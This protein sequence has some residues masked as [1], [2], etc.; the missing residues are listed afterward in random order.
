VSQE[1]QCATLSAGFASI[2]PPSSTAKG[3]SAQPYDACITFAT[4]LRRGT[5]NAG[6]ILWRFT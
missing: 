4:S 6:W 3:H 5:A 1:G 2:L